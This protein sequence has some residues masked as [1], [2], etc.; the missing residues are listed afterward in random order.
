MTTK[1]KLDST[2]G[3]PPSKKA[4]TNETLKYQGKRFVIVGELQTMSKTEVKTLVKRHGGK[5]QKRLSDKTNIAILGGF[6]DQVM[7]RILITK[8]IDVWNEQVFVR[9]TCLEPSNSTQ[10]TTSP[11]VDDNQNVLEKKLQD[12]KKYFDEQRPKMKEKY[13]EIWPRKKLDWKRI[14]MKKK[15]AMKQSELAKKYAKREENMLKMQIAELDRQ[16]GEDEENDKS[17]SQKPVIEQPPQIDESFMLK[18]RF[19]Y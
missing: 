9:K 4:K 16:L 18:Q 17:E 7:M 6:P 2:D 5:L 1:R 3:F 19:D 15:H 10:S 14:E 13:K 8:K 11:V 12:H